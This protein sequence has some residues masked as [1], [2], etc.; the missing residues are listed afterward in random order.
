MHNCERGCIYFNNMLSFQCVRLFA[1]ERLGKNP[2]ACKDKARHHGFT[3]VNVADVSDDEDMKAISTSY[4]NWSKDEDDC[5]LAYVDH[6]RCTSVVTKYFLYH[7]TPHTLQEHMNHL[8]H[9]MH[10]ISPVNR[11]FPAMSKRWDSRSGLQVQ[12]LNLTFQP[13]TQSHSL[14]CSLSFSFRFDGHPHG[15]CVQ[16]AVSAPACRGS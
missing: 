16:K 5:L 1:G 9:V 10:H 14:P 8:P 6:T 2:Y 15:V 13:P 12:F 3:P 7:I 11:V 4:L